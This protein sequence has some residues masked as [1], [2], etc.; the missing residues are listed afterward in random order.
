MFQHGFGVVLLRDFERIRPAMGGF[1][2]PAWSNTMAFNPFEP[3]TAPSPPRAAI[4]EGTR[5]LSMFCTPAD[6][7]FISPPGPINA[8]ATLSPYFSINFGAVS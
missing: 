2:P 4:R 1:P 6:F 7:I 8:I 3:I 5:S